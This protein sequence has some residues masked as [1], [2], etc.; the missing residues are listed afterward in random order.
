MG[1]MSDLNQPFYA[2]SVFRDGKQYPVAVWNG[3]RGCQSLPPDELIQQM[4]GKVMLAQI[5]RPMDNG[6]SAVRTLDKLCG[7]FD[8]VV[9]WAKNHKVYRSIRDEL[10]GIS[11]LVC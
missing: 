6:R 3:R 9:L 8:S 5:S 4:S 1:G 11:N 7:P 2:C 10:Q